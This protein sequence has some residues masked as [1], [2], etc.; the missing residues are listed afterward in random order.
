[1]SE[2]QA[3]SVIY[4]KLNSHFGD[5]HWWPAETDFEVIVGAIL[6]QNTAWQN[7]ERA[8]E[9][10]KTVHLLEPQLLY[11][12]DCRILEEL[13]R[14]S[15]YFRIK[16]SRIKNFLCFLYDHYT[17]N[18]GKMFQENLWQLR[19]KMLGI[20]G[21]GK[22]TADSILLYAGRK[23]VF[24][25]D[26][27]TKRIF[28]RHGMVASNTSYDELQKF[29]MSRLPEEV[30][31]YNQYHALIVTTGKKYC[32]AVPHCEECPLRSVHC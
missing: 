19:E 22:E 5:L 17:W 7:V 3:L 23:P 31:L 10:L 15:G 9:N 1:M 18:L 4:N 12:V 8:I 21:I 13:I 16:T 2:A 30:P 26:A 14:P 28:H 32:R 27:Y 24:V 29:F 6:T 11:E 25:I 20:T